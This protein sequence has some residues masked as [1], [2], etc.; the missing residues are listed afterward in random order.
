MPQAAAGRGVVQDAGRSPAPRDFDVRETDHEVEGDRLHRPRRAEG[1]GGE[2]RR[3]RPGDAGRPR[4]DP[5]AARERRP[6]PRPPVGD[7]VEAQRGLAVITP[8][9]IRSLTTWPWT[10]V[11]RKSLPAYL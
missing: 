4:I 8:Q 9:A 11:R 7:A 2:E 1:E 5:P 6:L 3:R 10:S